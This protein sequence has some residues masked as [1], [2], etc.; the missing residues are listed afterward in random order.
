MKYFVLLI[1]A[2][3]VISC[4][5]DANEKITEEIIEMSAES[6]GENVDVEIDS[7]DGKA[8]Y[9]VE[10]E[11]G[12]MKVEVGGE[13]PDA[14]PDDVYMIEGK[15]ASSVNSEEAIVVSLE[16][17]KKPEELKDVVDKEMKSNGWEV[18][19]SMNMPGSLSLVYKKGERTATYTMVK[20]EGNS[21][22][23]INISIYN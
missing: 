16:T 2:T 12:K 9:T 18:E 22:T 7:E 15:I 17:S 5:D 4:G 6:A 11:E 8:S 21:P 19:G 14:W 20:Y 13:L 1:L 23:S 3:L 10:T